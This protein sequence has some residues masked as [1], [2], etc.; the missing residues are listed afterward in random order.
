[1][2]LEEGDVLL[3]PLSIK[4]TDFLLGIRND[5]EFADEFFS[6]PPTY[7]FAHNSWLQSAAKNNIELIIEFKSERAGQIRLT[8]ID[9]R[10]QKAQFGIMIARSFQGKG[11]AFDSSRIF[12]EYVFRNL[13]INKIYLELFANNSPAMRLYEKLGFVEEGRFRQ[14][15]YKRGEFMDT[16][17]MSILR[18]EWGR[19]R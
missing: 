16:T 7:D 3:R 5:L 8:D 1:M 11:I 12:F 19:T 17:R 6:D 18:E 10:H 13:P 4:D 2:I 14:E 15:Y 9:Y